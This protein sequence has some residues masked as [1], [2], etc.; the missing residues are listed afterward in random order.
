MTLESH[1]P[2]HLL[3]VV[4]GMPSGGSCSQSNGYEI[5]RPDPNRIDVT[6]THHQVSDPDVVCTADYP[7]VETIVPLGADFETG[8]EYA[9]RVNSG[10]A[11]KFVAQ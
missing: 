5:R 7:I 1:P 9:V 3:R 11:Q 10:D 4:S 6:I 2:Q 8:V